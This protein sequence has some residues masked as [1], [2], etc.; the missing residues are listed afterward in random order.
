LG[1]RGK[2]VREIAASK[3]AAKT[4]F[5]DREREAAQLA[6][7]DAIAE[8]RGVSGYLVRRLF[9]EILDHA[10]RL[11]HERQISYANTGRRGGK[12]IVA[13]QGAVGAYSQLAAEQ[14]FAAAEAEIECLGQPSFV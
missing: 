6:R 13:F 3:A 5:Q 10:L 8:Q 12:L 7:L 1:E 14:H 2:L 11:Q 9:R 4:P